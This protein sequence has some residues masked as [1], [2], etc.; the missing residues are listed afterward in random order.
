[1]VDSIK[2]SEA[3][4]DAIKKMG[5]KIY[6]HV[7][8]EF[9]ENLGSTMERLK[10][11]QAEGKLNLRDLADLLRIYK[12]IIIPAVKKQEVERLRTIKDMV[13]ATE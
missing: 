6:E 1:M 5:D 7:D 3:I 10:T 2:I 13:E 4:E 12:N 11:K 9:V 8:R